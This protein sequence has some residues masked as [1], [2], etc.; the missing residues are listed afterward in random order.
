MVS[1]EHEKYQKR[2]S[3]LSTHFGPSSA[4]EAV[5]RLWHLKEAVGSAY[6]TLNLREYYDEELSFFVENTG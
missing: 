3:L 6:S 1:G 5:E 4:I 2:G